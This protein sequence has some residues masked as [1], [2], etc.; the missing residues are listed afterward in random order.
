MSCYLRGTKGIWPVNNC[1]ATVL[2]CWWLF[3]MSS[4]GSSP[5]LLNQQYTFGHIFCE[6]R[7]SVVTAMVRWSPRRARLVL[8][9]ATVSI[10]YLPS[11]PTQPSI[12]TGSVIEEWRIC[13]WV[14]E[15]GQVRGGDVNVICRPWH[16]VCLHCRL[17]TTKTEIT[18]TSSGRLCQG[19]LAYGGHLS[20]FLVVDGNTSDWTVARSS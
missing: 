7:F 16:S 20:F 1:V 14:T 4:I 9:W 15:V 6:W 12:L 8:G 13:K 2:S 11:R 5:Q 18:A 10:C 19:V 3:C 17:M